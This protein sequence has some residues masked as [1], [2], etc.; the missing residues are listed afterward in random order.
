MC[1][2]L[3]GMSGIGGFVTRIVDPVTNLSGGGGRR[4]SQPQ[5]VSFLTIGLLLPTSLLKKINKKKSKRNLISL[6]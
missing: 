6:Q 3:A 4:R 2:S 1:V 5:F